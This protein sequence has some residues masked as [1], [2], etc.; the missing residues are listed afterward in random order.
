MAIFSRR[1]VLRFLN[2]AAVRAALHVDVAYSSA[3]AASPY[4]AT[5]PRDTP[6]EWEV[7]RDASS[8]AF[9]H[10]APVSMLP[11]LDALLARG[12]RV[13]LYSGQARYGGDVCED[14][15]E[16]ATVS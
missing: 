13:L 7:C 11:T 9:A 14:D 16:E 1:C 6:A 8:R 5:R 15:A 2:D 4:G 3:A 10:D 12:V